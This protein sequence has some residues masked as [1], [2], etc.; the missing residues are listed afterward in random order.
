MRI[1]SVPFSARVAKEAVSCLC[2]MRIVA[3]ARAK[4]NLTAMN[5]PRPGKTA[6][7][8]TYT[9]PLN[10]ADPT[11]SACM[12]RFAAIA[13]GKHAGGVQLARARRKGAYNY[14]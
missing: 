6:A 8:T 5:I 12:Q 4:T 10:A 9:V 1:M 7:N 13:S 11:H 14:M 2:F 3:R